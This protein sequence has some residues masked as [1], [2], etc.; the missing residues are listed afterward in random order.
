MSDR[1]SWGP[2]SDHA[3][4]HEPIPAKPFMSSAIPTSFFFAEDWEIDLR[5][6]IYDSW[7]LIGPNANMMAPADVERTLSCEIKG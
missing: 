5:I 4:I 3:P 1:T 2:K 6:M 7:F